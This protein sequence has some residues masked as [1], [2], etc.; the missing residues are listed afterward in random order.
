MSTWESD[1]QQEYNGEI[2]V[3]T[4]MH[5]YEMSS[6]KQFYR[7]TFEN[8]H[9]IIFILYNYYIFSRIF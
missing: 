1:H 8:F 7:P 9:N 5:Q 6:M 2:P 4:T 3:T